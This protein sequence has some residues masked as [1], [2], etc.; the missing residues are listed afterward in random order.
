MLN[1]DV[2]YFTDLSHADTAPPTK[3]AKLVKSVHSMKMCSNFR[4]PL[5]LA[6]LMT[7]ML[8]WNIVWLL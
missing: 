7:A 3:C 1:G 6:P 2:P 4:W 8:S 5:K